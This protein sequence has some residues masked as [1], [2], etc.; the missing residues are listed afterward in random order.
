VPRFDRILSDYINSVIATGFI[1]KEIHE[2]RPTE[3][4]CRANPWLVRWRE[5]IPLFFYVRA[6]KPHR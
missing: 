4:A 1:L 2:P 3:E 6:L 5:N